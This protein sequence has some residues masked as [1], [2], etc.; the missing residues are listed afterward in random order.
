MDS[1]TLLNKWR[2]LI[3]PE[4]SSGFTPLSWDEVC[5]KPVIVFENESAVVVCIDGQLPSG[6]LMRNIWV[7]AGELPHVLRLVEQVEDSAR[8]AGKSA[9]VFM[10]RRGWVR[11]AVGYKEVV[12]IGIKEL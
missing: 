5:A 6:Q 12:T 3:E 1:V 10:G 4:T 9:V 7:A 8:N 11:S 2:H